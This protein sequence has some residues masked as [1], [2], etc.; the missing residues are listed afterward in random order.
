MWSDK[1]EDRGSGAKSK[2]VRG[3]CTVFGSGCTKQG[4]EATV[5][6]FISQKPPFFPRRVGGTRT[7][8]EDDD[9]VEDEDEDK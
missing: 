2:V 8:R 1:I 6:R 4:G 3:Q 9:E 5:H 7:M